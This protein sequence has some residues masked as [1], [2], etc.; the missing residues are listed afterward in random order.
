[1]VLFLAAA[2]AVY[3][4]DRQLPT[5]RRRRS[6]SSASARWGLF[7]SISR[8]RRARPGTRAGVA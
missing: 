5:Q 2:W 4:N 6:A 7:R 3:C 8:R 1:M